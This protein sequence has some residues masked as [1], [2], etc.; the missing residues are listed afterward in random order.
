MEGASTG[1]AQ[2]DSKA[3]RPLV[4]P[5]ARKCAGPDIAERGGT[6]AGASASMA[7]RRSP[8]GSL[9]S[10]GAAE[11]PRFAAFSARRNR[12]WFGKI[13]ARMLRSIFSKNGR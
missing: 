11:R 4:V 3:T 13:A 2:P 12:V 1:C 7:V 10:S 5:L 6:F 9:A 8:E